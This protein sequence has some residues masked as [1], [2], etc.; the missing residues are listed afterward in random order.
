MRHLPN[1]TSDERLLVGHETSDDGGVFQLT[2]DIALIQTID[3]FTP[4]VDDPYMFGQIAA[5]NALSDVYAMGGKPATVLNIVGYPIKTLPADILADILKGS[6]DKVAEAGAVIAGGHSIDDAEPKFGLSV[7]GTVHPERI[8]KNVGAKPG[9]VLVLTKPIGVG[10]LTTGIKRN[11]TTPEQ[12][13]LVTETMA[14]LNKHACEALSSFNPSA[15]TDVTGFGLLGHGYEIAKAS[16]VTFEIDYEKVPLLPGTKQLAKDGVVPGGTKANHHWLESII[17]YDASLTKEDE[18]IL[19]DAITSGGLLISM[20][21]EES[22]AYL[23]TLKSSVH[24]DAAIIGR[25]T[26]RNGDHFI[27]VK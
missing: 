5:A 15:V 11:K 1:T 22:K 19:C 3:Y 25:V 16:D 4:I 17:D 24:I 14:Q 2:N 21:E 18:L 27:T 13:K 7:T 9:D 12:E 26:E 8:F 23:S 20:S 6:S 10:I